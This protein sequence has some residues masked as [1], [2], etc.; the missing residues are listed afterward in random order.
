[1]ASFDVSGIVD[2]IIDLIP[3]FVALWILQ[4]FRNM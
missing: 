4:E 3:V 1:M 2:L